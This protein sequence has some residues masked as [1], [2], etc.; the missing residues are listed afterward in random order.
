MN[1]NNTERVPQEGHPR[2]HESLGLLERASIVAS[3]ILRAVQTIAGTE[4]C[5]GVQI[6]NLKKWAIE[7]GLWIDDPSTLGTF[8]DRGSENEVYLAYDNLY[9]FKLND[10]RYSDDN[11]TPF[12][13]RIEA[14]NMYFPDCA[15]QLT[16]LAE[17]SDGSTCAILR[18]RLI[19][20]AQLASQEDINRQLERMGFVSV[21]GGNYFT[22]GIHDIF[23]AVPNNVLRDG[24]G[25]L[26]FIDTIIF[27][28]GTDGLSIYKK[29]SPRGQ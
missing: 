9:V 13:E 2:E 14:H 17:N 18:Q 1:E 22:N 25:H 16:G 5:K 10:F 4:A 11:L 29:Y 23:D 28:S 20:D 7:E 15:Y 21:D 24:E 19:S 26:F 3:G 12:F 27:K 8:S 6:A